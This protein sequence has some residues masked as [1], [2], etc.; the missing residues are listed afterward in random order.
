[1]TLTLSIMMDRLAWV[2]EKVCVCVCVHCSKICT[3]EIDQFF[4]MENF[5]FM[6]SASFEWS[7]CDSIFFISNLTIPNDYYYYL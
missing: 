1:M 2:G 3:N 7:I 4:R 5:V 6:H